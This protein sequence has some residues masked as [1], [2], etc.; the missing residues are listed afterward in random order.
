[1]KDY[2]IVGCPLIF[3]KLTAY[4]I[5]KGV[6]IRVS[7]KMGSDFRINEIII[8]VLLNRKYEDFPDLSYYDKKQQSWIDLTFQSTEAIIHL[9]KQ[10]DV[11]Y[12]QAMY[13]L[14]DDR[15]LSVLCDWLRLN[16]SGSFTT[17]VSTAEAM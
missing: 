17:E 4:L 1:M 8:K 12:S 13:E 16:S 10:G 5:E 7:G 15:A 11:Y 2:S 3:P 6:N 14:Q 9:G